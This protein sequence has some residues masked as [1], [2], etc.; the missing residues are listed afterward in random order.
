MRDGTRDRIAAGIL[1]AVGVFALGNAAWMLL[2]SRGWF[3][4]IAHDTGSFNLHLVR[5]VAFAYGT[6]GG[7][8]LAA[9]LA[10]AARGPLAAAA[11]LFLGAHALGHVYEIAT[12]ALPFHHWWLD[13]PGVFLPA[14]LVA[15]VA[16]AS[17]R[18]RAAPAPRPDP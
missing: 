10:P 1:L 12:G 7:A 13:G 5:D 18:R 11:A 4:A 2:D 3:E 9:A 14:L 17:L 8:A 6:V 16:A 15:A